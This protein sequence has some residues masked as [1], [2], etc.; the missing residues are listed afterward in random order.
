MAGSWLSQGKRQWAY[1]FHVEFYT[2]GSGWSSPVAAGW[3]P[4]LYPRLHLLPNGNVFYSGST[5]GSMMFNPSNNTWTNVAGTNLGCTRTYG[6][7]VLLPLTPANGYDPKVMILGGG[8]PAT[9]TTELI[10]LGAGSPS[11]V[12]GPDMSQARIEMDAV[13]LPTGK[14]LALGGSASDENASTASLNADLYDPGSNSFSSG[15]ANTYARLYHSVA[16]LIARRDGLDCGQ[17]SRA[18]DLGIAHGELPA[19]V[20]V[21]PGWK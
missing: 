21:Y 13:I 3:T 14:V 9:A 10:D 15:G 20:S 8:N 5:S 19:S 11:W 6:S 17:Q 16:L 12:F 18:R 7:S 4:P 2:E 1:E